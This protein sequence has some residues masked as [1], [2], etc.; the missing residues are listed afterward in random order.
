MTKNKRK[1]IKVTEI[2]ECNECEFF[3]RYSQEEG[4][5]L[6]FNAFF[7]THG[8]GDDPKFISF[9]KSITFYIPD[10]CPRLEENGKLIGALSKE[11]KND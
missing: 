10:S 7:C 9:G 1:I 8:K 11:I 5:E 4:V 6:G 2:T 3:S